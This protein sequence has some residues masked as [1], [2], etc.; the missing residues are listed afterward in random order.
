MQ[1]LFGGFEEEY[2]AGG[3]GVAKDVVAAFEADRVDIESGDFVEG[4]V[5]VDIGQFEDDDAGLVEFGDEGFQRGGK[6][7]AFEVDGHHIVGDVA[8]LVAGGIHHVE[9]A[10]E[11]L[12]F[13]GR[14]GGRVKDLDTEFG[15]GEQ[16]AQ[17]IVSSGCDLSCL[18]VLAFEVGVED[19]LVLLF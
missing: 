12:L 5:G 19:F 9:D 14:E 7:L 10:L 6:A 11:Q 15:G 17:V 16:A 8:D 3:P 4:E 1:F 13:A 2:G 18:E